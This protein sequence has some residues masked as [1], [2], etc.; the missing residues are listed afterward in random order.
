MVA[1]LLLQPALVYSAGCYT[2]LMSADFGRLYVGADFGR[3][4]VG[5]KTYT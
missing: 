4:Y 1:S 2:H 5:A 3:L